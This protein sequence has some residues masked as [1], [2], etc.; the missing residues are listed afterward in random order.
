MPLTIE[1][2]ASNH[3]KTTDAKITY[4]YTGLTERGNTINAKAMTA[5]YRHDRSDWQVALN[6]YLET[7]KRLEHH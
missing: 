6:H 1:C 5:M 2:S 3:G 4:T 7:G